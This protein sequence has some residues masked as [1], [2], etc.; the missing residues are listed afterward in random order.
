MGRIYCKI[1][2]RSLCAHSPNSVITSG[3]SSSEHSPTSRDP[4]RGWLL[5]LILLN[6]VI[7]LFTFDDFGFAWD[8]P[9]FYAYGDAVDYAYSISARLSGNFDIENAYGPSAGDHKYYGPAYLL[10]VRPLVDALRQ[11]P[12]PGVHRDEWWHLVNFLTLQVGIVFF[13]K[14]ARRWV[15]PWAGLGAAALFAT[16]PVVWGH[17]MINPKDM[18]FM[19]FFILAVESGLTLVDHLR[20]TSPPASTEAAPPGEVFALARWTLWRVAVLVVGSMVLLT[21]LLAGPIQNGIRALVE[22]AYQAAPGSLLGRWFLWV[23]ARAPE[24]PPDAYVNKAWALFLRLRTGVTVLSVPLV[25]HTLVGLIW[26]AGMQNLGR[27]LSARLAPL[28][29]WPQ[30]R[31]GAPF[32]WRNAGWRLGVAALML[33]LLT[34]IRVLGPLVGALVVLYF[35]LQSYPRS[36]K[37]LLVYGLI[38]AGVTYLTWPFLWGNPLARLIEVARHMANNPHILPVLFNGQVFPSN[39][40]PR[41]YLPTLLGLTLTEPV[42]PL[43]VLG[44]GVGLVRFWRRSLEWRSFLILLLWVGLPLAY[45]LWRRPP[46]YDGYRHFLFLLPPLF[47]LAGLGLD[48]LFGWLRRGWQRVGLGFLLLFPGVI[49]LVRLHPYPYAYYNAFIGGVGGAFRRYETD[50]WLTCYKETMRL[51]N[52]EAR[53]HPVTLFVLRQPQIARRYAAPGVTV[54]SFDPA[55]DA[56]YPGS[57]LLLITRYNQDLTNHPEDPVRY[58]VGRAGAVFCVVK[59]VGGTAVP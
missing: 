56:T 24:T 8:E 12:V 25:L 21:Y 41:S 50:Y 53:D 15:G 54:Q 11:L 1:Q 34:S 52:A 10:L 31:A 3:F 9:L 2:A 58:T 6:L 17:G 42:F 28:P 47:V 20:A 48:A 16:Q 35:L 39:Q 23:A 45:V 59:E 19:V 37:P 27:A 44:S 14:L 29:I 32:R 22:A 49:G 13:Y 43:L 5:G 7:A 36:W 57:W 30:W 26:P 38:A 40:L 33:G 51:I 55:N 18:P 46:M 4:A